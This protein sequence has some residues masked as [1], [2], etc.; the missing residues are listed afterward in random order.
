MWVCS[1]L[2][3]CRL[4]FYPHGILGFIPHSPIPIMV[5]RAAGPPR[6]KAQPRFI[7]TFPL[8]HLPLYPFT[9]MPSMNLFVAVL[10]SVR[11]KFKR[12]KR[13]GAKAANKGG[14]PGRTTEN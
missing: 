5:R 2:T 10:R 1:Q 12:V 7:P 6:S 9:H 14:P 4:D 3:A 13:V 8:T 11:N